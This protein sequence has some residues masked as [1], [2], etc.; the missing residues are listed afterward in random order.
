VVVDRP[1]DMRRRH[2]DVNMF[3]VM[4]YEEGMLFAHAFRGSCDTETLVPILEEGVVR[5][6]WE[7]TYSPR[8]ASN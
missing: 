5:A 6:P 3:G 8:V 1:E 4:N 2:R 7:C